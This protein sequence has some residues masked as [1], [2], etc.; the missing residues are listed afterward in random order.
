LRADLLRRSAAT[1]AC[2]FPRLP[3]HTQHRALSGPGMA[4]DDAQIAPLRDAKND[5]G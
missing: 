3:R 2:R 1:E 5:G 4:E